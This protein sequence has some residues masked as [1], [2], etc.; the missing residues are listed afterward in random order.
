MKIRSKKL[1]T[2]NSHPSTSPLGYSLIE[3][4]SVVAIFA[5]VGTLVVSITA[6]TLRGSKKSDLTE[7]VRQS[8][9][10]TLSQ[11]VR[12]LRYAQTID[13]PACVPSSTSSEVDFTSMTGVQTKL[14]CDSTSKTITSNGVSIVDTTSVLVESCSFTCRQ[15]SNAN[16]PSVTIQFTL[17]S[18]NTTSFFENTVSVP[19]QSTVTLRNV[20]ER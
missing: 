5:I 17:K 8:G 14:I 6:F 13:S 2:L 9:A 19:F 4:L 1:S 7:S 18:N 16:L 11:M 3:L 12:N 15:S 20:I 10:A